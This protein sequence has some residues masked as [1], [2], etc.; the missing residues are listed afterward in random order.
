MTRPCGS[1]SHKSLLSGPLEKVCQALHQSTSG[2]GNIMCKDF[3][4]EKSLEK[5]RTW[6]IED[7]VA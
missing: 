3:E 5:L 1:Q 4:V 6:E 7:R 2:R